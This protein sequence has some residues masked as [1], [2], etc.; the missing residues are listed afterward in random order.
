MKSG[1]SGACHVIALQATPAWQV[2]HPLDLITGHEGRRLVVPCYPA[3][4][5]LWRVKRRRSW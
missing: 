3:R 4:G 5:Y 2:I 1:G